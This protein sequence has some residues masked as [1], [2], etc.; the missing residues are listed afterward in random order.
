MKFTHSGE[1]IKS[2]RTSMQMT[3]KEFGK[4]IDCSSQF[5]SNAERHLCAIPEK[6][7]KRLL[8]NTTFSKETYIEALSLDYSTHFSDKIKRAF[9]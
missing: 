3:Q 9:K 7:L 5:L 2:V 8:R 6:K 1:Y 4:M